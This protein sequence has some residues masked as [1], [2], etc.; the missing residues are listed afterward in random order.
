MRS[1][2]KALT[3]VPGSPVGSRQAKRLQLPFSPMH[4]V[5][6]YP[7]RRRW[8]QWLSL[9]INGFITLRRLGQP[10]ETLGGNGTYLL[11]NHCE[12]R[13][14]RQIGRARSKGSCHRQTIRVSWCAPGTSTAA[15]A[16]TVCSN[17]NGQ[18]R[19]PTQSR[20]FRRSQSAPPSAQKYQSWEATQRQVECLSITQAVILRMEAATIRRRL[21]GG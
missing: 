8:H 3:E 21:S 7:Y 9:P 19:Q 15:S 17:D 11:H 13:T 14:V 18:E 10:C 6:T 5:F 2:L 12:I 20:S 16:A 4:P 1:I